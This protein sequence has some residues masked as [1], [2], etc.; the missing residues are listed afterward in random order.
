MGV[1][2]FLA[3]NFKENDLLMVAR[4]ESGSPATGSAKLHQL[5]QRKIIEKAFGACTCENANANCRMLCAPNEWVFT[6]EAI[7]DEKI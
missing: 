3:R 6:P 1:W 5:R 4:P 2:P 7:K